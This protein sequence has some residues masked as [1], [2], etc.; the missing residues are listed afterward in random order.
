MQRCIWI[1]IVRFQGLLALLQIFLDP[2]PH[3]SISYPVFF[4]NLPKRHMLI[5]M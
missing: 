1:A 5:Q 3:K 4:L 2:C